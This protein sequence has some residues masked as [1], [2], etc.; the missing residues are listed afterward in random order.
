MGVLSPARWLRRPQ[1]EIVLGLAAVALGVIT[2]GIAGLLL[3]GVAGPHVR[4]PDGVRLSLGQVLPQGWAFFTRDP[5]SPDLAAYVRQADGT[6]VPQSRGRLAD[7]AS[8]FG[9][10]R[11]TRALGVETA[12]LAYGIPDKAW[13]PCSQAPAR[14]LE[15][16]PPLMSL[17]NTSTTR[18][19][20]GDVGLVQQQPPTF[21]FATLPNPG[22]PPSTVLRLH[23]SC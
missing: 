14:C 16:I 19:L 13:I 3:L 20:C 7:P 5:H 17:T 1:S 18:T 2:T 8:L 6:W 21:E 22:I 11:D 4:P 12:Y 9:F 23:V 15:A 10:D